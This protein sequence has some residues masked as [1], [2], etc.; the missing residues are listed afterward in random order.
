MSIDDGTLDLFGEVDGVE[1]IQKTPLF[2]G[3]GFEETQRLAEITRLE[4]FTKGTIIVEQDSLGQAL[5][6]L[7]QGQVTV[8]R[9]DSK[10]E[11]DTLATLGTGQ[12]FGEMSLV[13]D[14][15]VSADVEVTSADA[16]VLVIPRDAFQLLL[17]AND[18]LAVKVYKAFCRTLSDRLRAMTMRFAELHDEPKA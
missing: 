17:G 10:G 2:A 15:L 3:L 16:E 8:F 11:R 1:L 5:Y 18:R 7:R 6:I 14:M 12:V 9:R 13:D 4:H